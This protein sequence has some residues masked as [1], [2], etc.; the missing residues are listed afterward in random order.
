LYSIVSA[1]ASWLPLIP[2][3]KF[4]LIDDKKAIDQV[5]EHIVKQ[6]AEVKKKYA[7]NDNFTFVARY[8]DDQNVVDI[9]KKENK[10]FKADLIMMAAKGASNI[11]SLFIGSTINEIIN[12]DPFQ[13]I[14]ILKQRD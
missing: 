2:S 6:Y 4:P 13:D 11:P 7:V 12:T 1:T 14:Y 5:H 9:I 3:G 10:S 8:Q